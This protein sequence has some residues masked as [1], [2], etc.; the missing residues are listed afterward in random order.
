MMLDKIMLKMF[1]NQTLKL[2][3]CCQLL[4]GRSVWC[5]VSLDGPLPGLFQTLYQMELDADTQIYLNGILCVTYV[6][7]RQFTDQVV[8]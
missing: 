3:T 5:V 8:N 6:K 7:E 1:R 4:K 2:A